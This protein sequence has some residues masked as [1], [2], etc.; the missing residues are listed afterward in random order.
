M[1]RDRTFETFGRITRHSAVRV[2][3]GQRRKAIELEDGAK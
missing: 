2:A 3:A 1:G